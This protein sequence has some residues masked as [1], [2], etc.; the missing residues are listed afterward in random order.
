MWIL[1][2]LASTIDIAQRIVRPSS[3]PDWYLDHLQYISSQNFDAVL[4]SL[5]HGSEV[6][7]GFPILHLYPNKRSIA[8]GYYIDCGLNLYL[9]ANSDLTDN[10]DQYKF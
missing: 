9:N 10:L 3:W 5:K 7:N 4:I 8:K 1:F 6:Q 2:C